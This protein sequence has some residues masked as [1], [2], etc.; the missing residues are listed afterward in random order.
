MGLEVAH[1]AFVVNDAGFLESLH[2][3]S[4]IDI[5]VA[6]RVSDGEEGLF[7][8]HLVWDVFLM[9]PYVLEVGHW[10]VEVVVDN[11]FRQVKGPFAGI[12]DDGVEVNLEVQEADFWRSGFAVVGEFVATECQA[13]SV[14]FT[15]GEL[16]V[17]DKVG[18]GFFN[19]WGWR[20][21]R[22]IIWYWSL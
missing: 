11:V 6:T 16:D 4:D 13:K 8:D 17:A 15:F 22:K 7:N 19:L 14:R 20:V 1:N 2:P 3:L 21:W 5:D 18:I 10:I 12:G 9:D